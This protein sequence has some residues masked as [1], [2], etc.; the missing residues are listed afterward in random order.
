MSRNVYRGLLR[1]HPALYRERFAGE[2]LWIFDET[3][4][5]EGA[6][7]LLVDG[8]VSLMRQ[9]LIRRMTWKLAAAVLGA[10]LQVGVVAALTADHA[11]KQSSSGVHAASAT[12]LAKGPAVLSDDGLRVGATR[13]AAA[14]PRT[15]PVDDKPLAFLVL[16]GIVFVYACQRRGFRLRIARST[17]RRWLSPAQT[18]PGHTTAR[19][20]PHLSIVPE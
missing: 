3:V 5:S 11:T 15:M 8:V 14:I 10:L 19:A 6:A 17:E 12:A 1:L 16:F 18:Q 13:Q 20:K 9:W 2:M 7:A 4:A